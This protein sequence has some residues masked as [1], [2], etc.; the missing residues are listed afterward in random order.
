M[1]K[2]FSRFA[3]NLKPDLLIIGGGPGGYVSAIRASQLGLKTICVEKEE[4]L[5]GTCLREGCIP[6]KFL[7]N[8]SHHYH[9]IN[10]ELRTLGLNLKGK[11]EYDVPMIQRRKNAVLLQNSKG[12]EMLFKK[13][14]TVHEKGTAFIL[15][16]N[17]IEVKR[18]DGSSVVYNP[19]NLLIA[20]GSKAFTIPEYPVDEEVIVTSR[21]ALKFQQVPKSLFVIGAGVIG[22][23]MATCWNGL[24]SKVIVS[25]LTKTIGGDNLDPQA[26]RAIEMALKK[27]NIEFIL[28]PNKTTVK[29]NGDKAIVTI[30][31]KTYDV[32]KVLIS[33]GRRP[34]LDGFGLEKLGLQMNKNGTVQVNQ[35]YQTS[36]PGVY[37]IGDIVPGPQLAHKA[38]EEGVICVEGIAGKKV[39]ALNYDAI[40]GVI[41]T[42]PEVATVGLS[43]VEAKKK[44]IKVKVGS[45]PYTANSRARCTGQ[46]QGFVKWVCD[47]KGTV[48]GMTIVG[49]NAGEAILE[50]TI[51][52][53]NKM[54]VEQIAHTV[55]PHPTLSEAVMEAA[56][57]VMDKPIHI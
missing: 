33:I 45:F 44:G 26:A 28:G 20:S 46:T 55:H 23:E 10:S 22:L 37:A 52:I 8:V 27:R 49:P 41:Y 39:E 15:D 51:A 5:G 18:N 2:S 7:L 11:V 57:A 9:S 54:N 12:I 29:R 47:E 1:L 16:K 13:Y 36:I 40:P 30:G 53:Q 21:G 4:L 31:G 25:N 6:S 43:D 17:T 56:K 50:G 48:I 34:K 38:E 32:D 42:T 3:S 14:G 24:G 35:R 19:K